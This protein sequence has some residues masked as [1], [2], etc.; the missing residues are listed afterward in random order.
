M[1][2]A[3]LLPGFR[4]PI[5]PFPVER[6]DLPHPAVPAAIDGLRI[7]HITDTHVERRQ[8]GHRTFRGAL[9]ALATTEADLIALTGDYMTDPGHETAAIRSLAA[10][11]EAWRGSRAGAGPRFGAFGVFGNHDSAAMMRAARTIPGITWLDNRA[12]D[13]PGV[14][15]RIIGAS[16]PEDVLGAVLGR[17][18]EESERRPDE[19]AED[20]ASRSPIGTPERFTL[21]LAHYPTEVFPAAELGIPLV[22][23]GHTH[24]G[25]VRVSP[26]LAPHTSSELPMHLAGGLLRLRSTLCAVSRGLGETFVDWRF[27]CPAQ[28][29][30]YT[31]RKGELPGPKFSEET[32]T[33]VQVVAW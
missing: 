11:A 22:L 28:L 18:D 21:L 8:D 1:G 5:P 9:D 16:Y 7:L 30:L 32:G 20:A 29:P 31:L 26:R 25:Q 6:F 3:S 4:R 15:L 27:N 23:A 13:P 12:I 14:P 2:P 33:L 19:G 24:G 10:M 17:R